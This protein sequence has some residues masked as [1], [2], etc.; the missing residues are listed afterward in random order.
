MKRGDK[1]KANLCQANLP[2]LTS[3]GSTSR[4]PSSRGPSWSRPTSRR[5]TWVAPTS[6]RPSFGALTSRRP[7]CRRPSSRR[8]TCSRPSCK[9]PTCR[10]PTCR[11]PYLAAA[12]LQGAWLVG[13]NLQKADLRGANLQGAFLVDADLQEANL[14]APSSRRP[15]WAAPTSRT[16]TWSTPTSRRPTCSAPTSRGRLRGPTCQEAVYEPKLGTLPNYWT[17]TH[18]DNHLETLV[19]HNTPAALI[20]LREAFK[21]G[22]MRTQERQLTYAIEHTKQLQAWHPSWHN[23]K[24]KDTR[25]WSEQL[26]GKGE[27]LFSYVLFELPSALRHGPRTRLVGASRTDPHLC[28]ALLDGDQACQ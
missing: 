15:T 7:T 10:A 25:P 2:G 3:R 13:A 21:K 1:Q 28:G 4:G 14:V 6:R 24:V 23:P 9:R 20:A 17:L 16:P 26:T 5:P 11:R 22:G 27:S 19:F 18:P 12:P 8:P